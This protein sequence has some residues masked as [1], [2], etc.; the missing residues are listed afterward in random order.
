MPPPDWGRTRV[1]KKIAPHR[2]GTRKL[3]L[4]FG[5]ALVCVRHREDARGLTRF[6]TVELVVH[7][8]P[9][10]RRK[11]DHELLTV[12][13]EPTRPQ[14]VAKVVAAGGVWDPRLQAWHLTR[15]AARQLHLL[16][17]VLKARDQAGESWLDVDSELARY[18]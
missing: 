1:V 17:R 16:K 4:R 10:Q 9:I 18:G 6:I 7:E 5:Q 2:P 12:R 15:K 8:S 11:P 13:L 3:S 14:L